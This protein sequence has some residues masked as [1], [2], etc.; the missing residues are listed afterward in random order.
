MRRNGKM[1]RTYDPPIGIQILTGEEEEPEE[2]DR[3]Y[4]Q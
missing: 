1:R 4:R 2:A 3:S